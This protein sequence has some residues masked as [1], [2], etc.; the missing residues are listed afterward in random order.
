MECADRETLVMVMCES[1]EAVENI[2]A[3]VAVDGV[4]GVFMGPYDLSLS[5][6]IPG[7]IGDPVMVE[8]R[9]KVLAACKKAGKAPGIHELG[10]TRESVK[11]VVNEGFLFIALGVDAAFVDR[12]A[13]EA[14]K[15]ARDAAGL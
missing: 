8:A 12:G 13:K 1:R 10:M 15:N 7:R 9:R 11:Q 3:I 14:L 2:E 5:Y 4:D 6:G